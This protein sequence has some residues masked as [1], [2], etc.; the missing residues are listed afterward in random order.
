VWRKVRR[1]FPDKLQAANKLSVDDA[2]AQWTT[3]QNLQ[4]WFDDAKLDLI[5]T[6]LCIDQEVRGADGILLSELDFRSD[7]VKRR[8]LYM[9]ETHHDLLV[10][11]DRGGPRSVTY[12]NP[13]FQRGC[14]RGVQSSRHVT[15]VYATSAAGEN[16]PP[17]Y[18]FDSGAKIEDNFRVKMKWLDGLPTVTGR[19]GCPSIVESSSFYAVRTKGSMDDSLFNSYIDDVILPLFPNISKHASFDAA[20]GTFVALF[21]WTAINFVTHTFVSCLI[22]KASRWSCRT[23]GGFWSRSYSQLA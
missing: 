5:A 11:G 23:Q 21:N 2:R 14:K 17:M 3:H 4:Q 12:H 15:G 19:F 7:E 6:G 10:T 1:E 13:R 18:T 20:T 16:I 8:I 22:R 9:D